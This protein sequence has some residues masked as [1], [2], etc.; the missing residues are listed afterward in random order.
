MAKPTNT[1]DTHSEDDERPTDTGFAAWLNAAMAEA[2][3]ALDR[4][5]ADFRAT[6]DALGGNQPT[7]SDDPDPGA[8]TSTE[9]QEP[10]SA[11]AC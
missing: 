3:A 10:S 2:H 11:I 5:Q 1:P 9:S 7:E 4:L 6:A 8:E